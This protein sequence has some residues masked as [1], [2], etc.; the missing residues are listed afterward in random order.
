MFSITQKLIRTTALTSLVTIGSLISI[1]AASAFSVTYGDSNATDGNSGFESGSFNNAAGQTVWNGIGD[2][3]V[4]GDFKT[5]VPYSL[6]FQGVI[7]TACSGSASAECV[8]TSGL[9]DTV[10]NDDNPATTGTYN[11]SGSEPVSASVEISDLQDF[12]G[13]SAG[14][15]Q[16]PR[17]GGTIGGT[18]TP[19]EGS[20]ITQTF[21]ADGDFTLSFNWNYL[22]ND[23][24]SDRFGNQDYAFVTLYETGSAIG[25]RTITVLEDSS[26]T[27]NI[28]SEPNGTEYLTEGAYQPYTFNET[29]PAGEYTLG[30]GVVDVDGVDR[31][32]ALLLDEMVVQ[33]IPFEFSPTSGLGLVAG[34]IG[35]T[36]LRRKLKD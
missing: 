32:S 24:Q 4:Q 23:G 18:R 20:A 35:L 27:T 31:S 3:S 5:V 33:E 21:T 34:F 36:K 8:G 25:E 7:T 10:R 28:A 1:D 15:L 6:N 29:F 16:I 17:Q 30:Y 22:T 12:L 14:T 11:A 19:K 9:P 13:L 2:A 26:S